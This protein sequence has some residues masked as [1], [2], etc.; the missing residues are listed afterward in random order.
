MKHAAKKP[1]ASSLA[2]S[3]ALSLIAVA[4]MTALLQV[5]HQPSS[6]CNEP[7]TYR[8]GSVDARF[9]LNADEVRHAVHEAVSLWDMASGREL[10][11]EDPQ[12]DIEIN[13]VYDYRQEASDRLKG[14]TGTM[15]NS[16][17]SYE[18]LKAHL[19]GMESDFRQKK[20]EL[21]RDLA[22]YN[23]R[24]SSLVAQGE[25]QAQRDSL[26]SLRHDLLLRQ[27]ELKR[28]TDTMNSMVVLVNELAHNLNLGVSDYNNTGQRLGNEFSEGLY[29]R[30]GG[31]ETIIIFHFTN[32]TRLVRV[33][34]HELGHAL[35]LGHVDDP[36]A[37]MYRLNLS[38]SLEIS[39]VDIQALKT[40][41]SD[42]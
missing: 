9:R 32:H 2:R 21:E 1:K 33:L 36:R 10:F 6:P 14:I 12:G 30:K 31:R 23:A 4:A 15:E 26:D 5:F 19:E 38:E 24:I 28:M 25:A 20:A 35:G 3:L 29:E 18:A 37:L 17:R 22:D 40:R 8:I 34:A 16:K 27:D 42:E 11:R 13:L 41:C 39:P 7:L